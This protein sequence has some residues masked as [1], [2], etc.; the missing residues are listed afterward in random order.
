MFCV[1]FIGNTF[2][3]CVCCNKDFASSKYKIDRHVT[4]GTHEKNETGVRGI[5]EIPQFINKEMALMQIIRAMEV[6]IA[7]KKNPEKSEYK[8]S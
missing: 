4:S 3:H 8:V 1:H 6:R 2:C 5:L 7:M